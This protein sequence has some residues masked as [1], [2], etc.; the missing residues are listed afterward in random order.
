MRA[1]ATATQTNVAT[2]TFDVIVDPAAIDGT[3]ISNQSFVSSVNGNVVDTPSD[4]PN[5]PV[6]NDPTRNVVGY[7]SL[8][9]AAKRA[10]LQVDNGTAGVVDPGDVLRYTITV[11]NTGAIAA[12]GAVLQDAIPANT[13]YVANSLT[14]NGLPVGQPDGGVS[15]MIAGVNISSS[16]LTPPLPG[17][18]QGTLSANQSAVVQFD[19]RVNDGVA[20]GTLIV[21]QATVLSQ[22]TP[23]LRT[24]GDGNPSTGPE[25]TVVIVVPA[26]RLTI[27]KQVAVVG[28]GP[29]LAG[30]QLEYLVSITNISAVPASYVEIYDDLD[31]NAPG[32][33]TF[34]G[35][36]ATLNGA[37]T[38]ISITGSVLT[39][40]YF[41]TYGA[42][43]PGQ[44]AVLR[45]R[46]Y[47]SRI[48]SLSARG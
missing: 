43:A 28:G 8:L 25:P 9:F 38:G 39:A 27:T 26:P 30:S 18:G 12:T 37:T 23:A 36:T 3:V 13:T 16:D 41:T 22:K 45:F 24:D 46:A 2:F 32:Y 10:A 5:T 1:D 4:D 14:L 47:I 20:S 31:A 34:V 35:D 17:A 48:V 44:T 42:L 15:P 29:A 11:Y 7:R 19:M 21:N 33:L 6:L 40:D